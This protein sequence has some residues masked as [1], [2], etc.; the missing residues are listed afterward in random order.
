MPDL[1]FR[2]YFADSPASVEDL[3]DIE[4]ITVEQQEDAAWEARLVLSH[5]LDERGNWARQGDLRLR[6]RT[7]VR[8][9]LKI[10][11]DDFKPLIDGPI[12]GIHTAMDSRPGRSTAT[13]V[14]HDNSAWLNLESKPVVTTGKSDEEIARLLFGLSQ[15]P[16]LAQQIEIPVRGSPPSLGEEFA[17][18]GTPMQM[19]RHLAQR[20]ACHAYVLPGDT[21]GSQSI[22]C[23]KP[24]P[25]SPGTLP[26]LVLLGEGLNLADVTVT[27]DPEKSESTTMHT[28]RLADQEIVSYSTQFSDEKLLGS[29][30]AASK[31]PQ[32]TLAPHLNDSEDPARRARA[33]S[34]RQNYPVK[35]SGSLI[36]CVYPKILR[37][38]EKVS[39]HAGAAKQSTVVLLTKVTHRI[40]PSMYSVEF[41]G[42]TNSFSELQPAV[43]GL[44]A[45]IL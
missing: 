17:Q 42:R 31:P 23:L 25:E 3:L 19:L 21:A 28:L 15:G 43:P 38:Y 8:I 10:G 40:T 36:P 44:P 4:E 35:L 1:S 20:N 22:G 16:Q 26:P 2:V 32:R 11:S 41:E 9:E 12:V 34:R 30:P 29:Q 37:P 39:L 5:C 7:Q 14:V 13:I 18:L 24:D 27:E 33:R 6:S 45:G